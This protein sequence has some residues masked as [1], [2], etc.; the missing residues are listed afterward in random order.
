MKPEF[1]GTRRTFIKY[2]VLSGGLAG[3]LGKARP[4]AAAPKRPPQ[5]SEGSS[6]GYRLTEHVKRYYE[7]ARM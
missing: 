4:A 5:M 2:F 1:K 3:L 7:R 6:R